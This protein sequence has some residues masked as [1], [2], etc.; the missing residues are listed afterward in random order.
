MDSKWQWVQRIM[1]DDERW[2][3]RPLSR[4]LSSLGSG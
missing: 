4:H 2:A 1:N 3:P